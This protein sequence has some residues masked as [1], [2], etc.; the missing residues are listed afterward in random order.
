M[1]TRQQ[2][3][4][5][6]DQNQ[7]KLEDI[8]G[9]LDIL[10]DITGKAATQSKAMG[11]ELDRQNEQIRNI[12]DHMDRTDAGINKATNKVVEVQEAT[13]SGKISWVVCVVLIILCVVLLVV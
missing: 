9:K 8:D 6:Y 12:N 7:K 13:K 10:V 5:T 2:N 1:A 3:E 4:V 11:N